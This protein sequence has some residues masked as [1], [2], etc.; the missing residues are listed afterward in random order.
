MNRTALRPGAE[1]LRPTVVS[2]ASWLAGH[3]LWGANL[4]SLAYL[5]FAI[6]APM[7]M[8]T[9]YFL[10]GRVVYAAYSYL[11]HQ[12]PDRSYFLFGPE[13]RYSLAELR[14]WLGTE[15]SRYY[16]GDS[17]LGYKVAICQR[18]VAM[19]G[20]ML[21]G[22][23]AYGLARRRRD[24][25]KP[26]SWWGVLI[27]LVPVAVDGGGQLIGLWESTWLVRTITGGLFGV[28]WVGWV[29]PLLDEAMMEMLRSMEDVSRAREVTN[30][31]KRKI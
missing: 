20:I 6:L 5:G 8:A 18:C 30:Q 1:R 27:L 12:W 14:L 3:W 19:Y 21:L 24:G 25:M 9:G 10:S 17:A 4:F 29:Y 15:V 2:L 31:W 16:V 23:L 28:A 11:C 26:L 13:A 22:G 7:L